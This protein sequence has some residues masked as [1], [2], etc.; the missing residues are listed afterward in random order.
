MAGQRRIL[1]KAFVGIFAENR[2]DA[3]PE[4]KCKPP[5]AQES[6]TRIGY[7]PERDYK[8]TNTP[9]ERDRAL[10]A[11]DPCPPFQGNSTDEPEVRR[12]WEG[13]E[14]TGAVG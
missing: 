2:P 5:R 13:D 7:F 6:V 9:R 8:Q 3:T 14:N 10:C 1:R 12:S 4:W 11:C